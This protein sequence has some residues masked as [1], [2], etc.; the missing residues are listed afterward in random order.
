MG[1]KRG[2]AVKLSGLKSTEAP[3]ERTKSGIV[4]LI[5]LWVGGSSRPQRFWL[6]VIRE[7]VNQHCCCRP[8]HDLLKLA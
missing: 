2:A 1:T 5:G 8:L 4:E 7:L 6:A 3:P